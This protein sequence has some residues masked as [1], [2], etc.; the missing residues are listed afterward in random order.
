MACL[1]KIV[2]VIVPGERKTWMTKV[3]RRQ[4]EGNYNLP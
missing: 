3:S 4:E 2:G 1:R